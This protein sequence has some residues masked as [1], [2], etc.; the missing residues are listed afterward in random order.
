MRK[1]GLYACALVC[2]MLFAGMQTASA[3]APILK[4]EGDKAKFLTMQ[5]Q[6]NQV[7]PDM[8]KEARFKAIANNTL[9]P[10]VRAELENQKEAA[11]ILQRINVLTALRDNQ[12]N[13]GGPTEKYDNALGKLTSQ[14]NAMIGNN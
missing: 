5:E 6:L 1:L 3:Q 14:Y 12:I 2:M 11:L 13:E 4:D 7:T 8:E 10:D 9:K